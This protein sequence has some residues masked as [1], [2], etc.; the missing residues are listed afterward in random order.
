PFD[1]GPARRTDR[2]A[3]LPTHGPELELET[4]ELAREGHCEGS[5]LLGLL[6]EV[7]ALVQLEV[8]EARVVGDL[9][10][11][12]GQA[13]ERDTRE[14]EIDEI[15]DALAR[16]DLHQRQQ[17][18]LQSLGGK[19]RLG[20]EDEAGRPPEIAVRDERDANP[21]RSVLQVD[22]NGVAL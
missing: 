18:G 13:A 9:P 8:E 17:A 7:A 16:A 2:P 3:S 4:G 10:R 6:P 1:R 19:L 14:I 11:R 5:R 15:P 20:R 12:H 22:R 21:V